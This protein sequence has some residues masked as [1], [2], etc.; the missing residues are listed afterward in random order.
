[1]LTQL[2]YFIP[3]TFCG[4][5]INAVVTRDV[6]MVRQE[7]LQKHCTKHQRKFKIELLN[8]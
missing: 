1:M 3:C 7:M 8:D 5:L 4:S 2:N 6:Y